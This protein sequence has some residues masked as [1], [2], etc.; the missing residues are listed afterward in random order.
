MICCRSN[1]SSAKFAFALIPPVLRCKNLSVPSGGKGI[2]PVTEEIDLLGVVGVPLL[3]GEAVP[4]KCA[5][6]F[7][8]Y[9]FVI[10]EYPVGGDDMWCADGEVL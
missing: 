1:F 3:L 10:I 5:G 6:D 7:R 8:L 9:L 2:L 4:V